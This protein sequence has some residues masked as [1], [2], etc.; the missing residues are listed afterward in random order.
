MIII[1]SVFW[2]LILIKRQ[3]N[4]KQNHICVWGYVVSEMIWFQLIPWEDLNKKGEVKK[5]NVL[6]LRDAIKIG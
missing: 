1:I 3:F 2:F 5:M 4:E 6:Y